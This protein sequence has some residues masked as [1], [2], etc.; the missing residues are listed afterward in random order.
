MFLSNQ[1]YIF[2]GR[3]DVCGSFGISE[4]FK[5]TGSSVKVVVGLDAKGTVTPLLYHDKDK[6]FTGLADI[7]KSEEDIK[8]YLS[9]NRGIYA[10]MG[11]AVYFAEYKHPTKR[12][13][14]SVTIYVPSKD[15]TADGKPAI[16]CY[17][18]SKSDGANLMKVGEKTY[19]LLE[20]DVLRQ[21]EEF[22][23]TDR[24]SYLRSR[25]KGGVE[26]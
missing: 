13:K 5:N 23:Y 2:E 16:A 1:G 15:V 9:S 18:L 11:S 6:G 19:D 26:T 14:S 21:M 22:D 20:S 7:C 8:K 17:K 10:K 12:G 24:G 3:K 4:S 25:L